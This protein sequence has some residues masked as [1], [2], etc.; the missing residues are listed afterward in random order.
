MKNILDGIKFGSLKAM[1]A[2]TIL[3][4]GGGQDSTAL[5]WL[6]IKGKLKKFVKGKFIVVM[7]D[8]G[9]EHEHT[10]EHLKEI[11]ALCERF[12]IPFFHIGP[13]HGYYS[14][15]WTDVL[16]PQL[17]S[18]DDEFEPTLIQAGTKSCTINVK[19]API[20]KFVDHFIGHVKGYTDKKDQ[21]WQRWTRGGGYGQKAIVKF[22]EDH[23]KINVLIG[24]AHGEEKRINSAKALEETAFKKMDKTNARCFVKRFFPLADMMMDRQACQKFIMSCAGSVPYPSNCV[25][26]PYMAMEELLWLN[27]HHED[28]MNQWM[29]IEEAKIARFEAKRDPD[30]N[31]YSKKGNV[32]DNQGV[33]RGKETLREKLAKVKEKY[34]H[35]TRDELI[36]FLDDF[37]MNHSNCGSSGH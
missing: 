8:T 10:K 3:S 37:K 9:D 22:H 35:M 33:Y 25:L 7:A 12:D 26:C 21:P 18:E 28:R 32:I 5:L 36:K 14:P 17:R 11:R 19:V 34:S 27:L 2:L 16:T 6:Y 15:S 1:D 13:Q 24:F 29:E 31:I 20:Y 4:F 30:G 23:G